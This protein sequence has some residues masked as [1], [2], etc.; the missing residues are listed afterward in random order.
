MLYKSK[1]EGMLLLMMI[2]WANLSIW[3]VAAAAALTTN[4]NYN[5]RFW[6]LWCLET[7]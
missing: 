4:T 1:W 6:T 5:G 7:K 3:S 2:P